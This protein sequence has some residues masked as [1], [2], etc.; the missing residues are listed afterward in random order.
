[1]SDETEEEYLQRLFA[2]VQTPPPVCHGPSLL[3]ACIRD[4]P[5]PQPQPQPA[6]SAV[7]QQHGILR[8]DEHS[9]QTPTDD[10]PRFHEPVIP[11]RP[12]LH[13]HHHSR[14][15]AATTSI[16]T[17]PTPQ[18][19]QTTITFADHNTPR[20]NTTDRELLASL[21]NGIQNT[22]PDRISQ[23]QQ[24]QQHND[25]HEDHSLATSPS[26]LGRRSRPSSSLGWRP[27]AIASPPPQLNSRSA[28][29]SPRPGSS[30]PPSSRVHVEPTT[31]P[32]PTTATTKKKF[33]WW[34]PERLV[35]LQ[36][37][38][39]DRI[40]AG[41]VRTSSGAGLSG[42]GKQ[43]EGAGVG[44][45]R[46][47]SAG[48][49]PLRLS[50]DS[51]VFDETNVE[52]AGAG[53][54]AKGKGRSMVISQEGIP[55][56]SGGGGRPF[57]PGRSIS[58]VDP[59]A[60]ARL[61]FTS[62]EHRLASSPFVAVDPVTVGGGTGTGTSPQRVLSPSSVSISNG[63]GAV[64]QDLHLNPAPAPAPVAARHIQFVE[65]HSSSPK[66]ALS[67]PILSPAQDEHTTTAPISVAVAA[68]HIQF[69]ETKSASSSSPKRAL[70]PPIVNTCQLESNK[71]P[72]PRDPAISNPAP[73]A[74]RHIQFVPPSSPPRHL[75]RRA[76][77]AAAAG[78]GMKG[79]SEREDESAERRRKS[80]HGLGL[81]DREVVH[82]FRLG[83]CI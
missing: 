67:P 45:A 69:A 31:T 5:L 66:R 7:K 81:E 77:A 14:H 18:R 24:Q 28:E 53:A 1:M 58:M 42:G 56:R 15:S 36:N 22:Q 71:S 20:D 12:H 21:C 59:A 13:H 47:L 25:E 51:G 50:L 11:H 44:T 9:Q 46:R 10:H 62:R 72:T 17:A 6:T 2:K 63:G 39:R 54:G 83:E 43:D 4:H 79:S 27:F 33:P 60:G 29:A 74:A 57:H 48:S 19:R 70:S 64:Q 40:T 23:Q 65:T 75:R 30:P 52:K 55:A 38:A 8:R 26:A 61:A 73:T 34:P 3:T 16:L 76:A 80:F 32:T 78:G 68:R 41:T 82:S 37:A 35:A 49:T